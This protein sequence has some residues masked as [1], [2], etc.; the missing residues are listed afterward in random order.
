MSGFCEDTNR[1]DSDVS[2]SLGELSGVNEVDGI[3][4]VGNGGGS[5]YFGCKVEVGIIADG[6]E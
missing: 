6:V 3:A 2:S 5:G 1:T 4:E